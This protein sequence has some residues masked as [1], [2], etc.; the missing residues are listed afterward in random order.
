MALD[1]T[2]SFREDKN[3]K[4]SSHFLSLKLYTTNPFIKPQGHLHSQKTQEE[5]LQRINVITDEN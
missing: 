3:V 1:D 5:E 4:V 2:I